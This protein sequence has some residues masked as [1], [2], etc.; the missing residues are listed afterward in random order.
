MIARRAASRVSGA[1][2]GCL[3]MSTVVPIWASLAPGEPTKAAAVVDV[4]LVVVLLGLFGALHSRFGKAVTV[5]ARAKSYEV[6][7]WLA[8]VPLILFVLFAVGVRLK[9]YVLL[10]GLGWRSWYLVTILPLLFVASGRGR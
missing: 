1:T 8:V 2:L 6:C 4:T 9:W 10:I 7:K 3:A 5:D